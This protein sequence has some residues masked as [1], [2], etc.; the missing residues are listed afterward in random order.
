MSESA[1]ATASDKTKPQYDFKKL[2]R[3]WYLQAFS[4]EY[5][6]EQVEA[7]LLSKLPFFPNSDG[8]RVAKFVNTDIGNGRHIHEFYIE[9]IEPP[10]DAGRGGN[11]G[12]NTKLAAAATS[13]SD[14]NAG[15]QPAL[16]LPKQPYTRD[17]VL[18][19]GYAAS[20]GLF[21][22]NFDS[23]SAV[24]GIRIHAI[25]LLGFGFLSRPAF[26]KLP[27]ATKDDIYK[28]EDWFVDS[29]EEWRKRRGID[30]F[31][32]VG[33]SFGGYL[34]CAY[35]LKYQ[36]EQAPLDRLVLLSP[37]GVERH[38]NSLLTNE[39][40]PQGQVSDTELRRENSAS[41]PV[42][43]SAEVNA[44]QQDIVHGRTSGTRTSHGSA[45]STPG[46]ESEIVP[47]DDDDDAAS[48]ERRNFKVL[49]EPSTEPPSRGARVA[50]YLWAKNVSPFS[51]VRNVG[52]WRSK[53]ISNW[54]MHR[55]SSYH[56]Q[57]P[58]QYQYIH[59]YF[60]RVFNGRGSGEYAITRILGWGALAK[61]PLLDRCPPKF[62]RMN[63]PTMW[64]YGDKDWMNEKAGEEMVQEINN[65]AEQERGSKLATY[66]ILKNAGHHL[67]L[68]NPTDTKAALAEF[69]GWA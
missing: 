2:A 9:N 13:P 15:L 30:K 69:C 57:D 14:T 37:V 68:D 53:I 60:Y 63:L 12:G 4:K 61:C 21:F 42:D 45:G 7:R 39:A 1:V 41:Q 11:S 44:D 32:L 31:V 33:H 55:F 23:L 38:R 24:P 64:L 49:A 52:P 36:K 43:I 8:K 29:M 56:R 10:R 35:A 3:D 40:H 28:V 6:D 18:V 48:R 65:L 22:E 34:S 54:T 17:V 66:G 46:G 47:L 5:S 50:R 20:L 25:D 19:H 51:L 58:Q 59:D 62:V 67:Y 16:D 27:S 26:P